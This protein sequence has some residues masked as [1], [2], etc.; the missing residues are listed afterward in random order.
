MERHFPIRLDLRESIVNVREYF[1]M[2]KIIKTKSI[3]DPKERSDG[4]RVLITR[5]YPRRIKRDISIS[6]RGKHLISQIS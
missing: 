1:Y 3:Y 2:A 4:V 6:G 5:F